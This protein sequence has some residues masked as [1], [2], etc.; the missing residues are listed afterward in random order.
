[1]MN[2]DNYELAAQD[3][4]QEQ[5]SPPSLLPA[6]L[7]SGASELSIVSS[8]SGVVSTDSLLKRLKA[9]VLKEHGLVLQSQATMLIHAMNA[10]EALLRLKKSLSSV[11]F[12]EWLAAGDQ[13][14]LSLT[15]R[16]AQ[17]Y[18]QVA[19]RADE[20][21][22]LRAEGTGR[23][24]DAVTRDELLQNV[25]IRKAIAMLSQR[26]TASPRRIA[27]AKNASNRVLT[28][29]SI[30]EAIVRCTG[31]LTLDPAADPEEPYYT[32]ATMAWGP[33]ED[34]LSDEREWTGTVFLH[35]PHESQ[36][37]WIR[38]AIAEH[39]KSSTETIMLLIEARSDT[40]AF[41]LLKAFPRI[42]LHSRIPGFKHPATVFVLSRVMPPEQIAS[43]FAE[44]GDT[45]VPV[46]L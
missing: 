10:G 2:D 41:R 20:I 18:M 24:A 9:E 12:R 46:V 17:R 4:P 28:P 42:F 44:L 5:S 14:G 25:S 35:P 19:S 7:L 37:A 33:D 31:S 6:T 32:G 22:R 30:L 29:P 11:A 38:R 8:E 13:H 27:A 40:E 39:R 16:T 1:M 21:Q 36:A 45:F 34:G 23:R 15:L 3:V 26:D 43:S